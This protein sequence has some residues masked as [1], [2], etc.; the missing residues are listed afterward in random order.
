MTAS[1]KLDASN[2]SYTHTWI[3]RFVSAKNSSKNSAALIDAMS[4]Y[5]PELASDF[6]L[7]L[8]AQVHM[9]EAKW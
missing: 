6:S 7:E 5:Y 8:G 1:G 9:K 2:I 3:E 4:E